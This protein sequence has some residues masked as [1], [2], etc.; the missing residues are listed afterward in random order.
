MAYI[1]ENGEVRVRKPKPKRVISKWDVVAGAVLE[2]LFMSVIAISLFE[3]RLSSG[4]EEIPKTIMLAAFL[5]FLLTFLIVCVETNL[6]H[7][8]LDQKL[9]EL[10]G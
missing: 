5:C 2:A 6:R 9:N 1:D 3:W 10:K 4:G 8:K 7:W